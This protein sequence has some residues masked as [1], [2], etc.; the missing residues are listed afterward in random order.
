MVI[1]GS[2]W[3]PELPP[4]DEVEV[5][6]GVALLH[7]PF[8]G[9]DILVAVCQ[10]RRITVKV[11]P[12]VGKVCA[13]G[14]HPRVSIS[15][16]QHKVPGS[17]PT[18]DVGLEEARGIHISSSSGLEPGNPQG[19]AQE[20]GYGFP[21]AQHCGHSLKIRCTS[22]FRVAGV[23]Q[24][25]VWGR[26][27]RKRIRGNGNTVPGNVLTTRLCLTRRSNCRGKRKYGVVHIGRGGGNHITRCGVCTG[28]SYSPGPYVPHARLGIARPRGA[29]RIG[30]RPAAAGDR[31]G[32]PGVGVTTR[33]L[34]AGLG[35]GGATGIGPALASPSTAHRTSTPPT[36]AVWVTRG[37][38]IPPVSTLITGTGLPRRNGI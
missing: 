1:V 20:P 36:P 17:G 16:V 38:T 29:T 12:R 15:V 4:P 2:Q 26:N 5:F 28:N 23:L 11:I 22:C 9:G 10:E 37:R 6:D 13:V 14:D 31:T 34:V 30:L 7:V 27:L 25:P 32:S 3:S 8:G 24:Y 21:I 35:L 19:V 33:Q 18:G